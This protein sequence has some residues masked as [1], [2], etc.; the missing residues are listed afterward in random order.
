[1]QD[2][3]TGKSGDFAFDNPAF[4]SD[5][6]K[7]QSSPLDTKWMGGNGT[8]T[9]AEKRK[10]QD[11]HAAGNGMSQSRVIGLRGSDFTGLGIELCGG[12]KEGIFVRKVMP[13]GPATGLVNV[14]D[15]IT[16]I[17]IDC[18][19]LVLEDAVSILSYASPYNVQLELVDAKANV[20][21]MSHAN[22]PKSNTSTLSHPLYRSGSQSDVNTVSGGGGNFLF[23]TIIYSIN[24]CN[25]SSSS[26]DWTKLEKEPVPGGQQ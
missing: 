8:L 12:L 5:G 13:Q 21:A 16:S 26:V 25:S 18:S 20:A 23:V 2:P 6:T 10:S 3:E 14:G 15:K 22:S 11:D 7:V 24:K 19:H 17:T 9:T 1:M 4:K